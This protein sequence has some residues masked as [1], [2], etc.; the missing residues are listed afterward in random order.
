MGMVLF[1]A[2]G[3]TQASGEGDFLLVIIGDV[4]DKNGNELGTLD[5]IAIEAIAAWESVLRQ[6]GLAT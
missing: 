2:R 1:D 4:V 3:R 6:Y 5:F